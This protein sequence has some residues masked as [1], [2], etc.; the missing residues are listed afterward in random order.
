MACSL[1]KISIE[2]AIADRVSVNLSEELRKIKSKEKDKI[3]LKQVPSLL[4]SVSKKFKSAMMRLIV[5]VINEADDRKFESS[6]VVMRPYKEEAV[7]DIFKI[8]TIQKIVL[9]LG[10]LGTFIGLFIAF[11]NLGDLSKIDDNFSK[12]TNALQYSFSTSIAGLQASVMLAFFLLLLNRRQDSYFKSMEDATQTTIALVRKSLNKDSF[13]ADFEQMRESMDQVRKSVYD[14][15]AE[16]K[17]QTKAIQDGILKLKGAK[18]NFDDFLKGMTQEMKSVYDILSPE[19]ISNELKY[20]LKHSVGGISEAL[21]DNITRHLKQYNVLN[22]SMAK[23]SKNLE[24]IDRQLSGQIELN[25][26][27]IVKAKNEIYKA[28]SNLSDIQKKYI[29]EVAVNHPGKQLEM[30]VKTIERDISGKLGNNANNILDTMKRLERTLKGYSGIIENKVV[31]SRKRVVFWSVLVT[32][33]LFGLLVIA[34]CIFNPN[35]INSLTQGI[36]SFIA[37]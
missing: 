35:L 7:G 12:I 23:I 37:K 27:T 19:K 21:N 20:S 18:T 32:S 6:D 33:L 31:F 30:A 16:T 3:N 34:V 4:P 26:E 24:L 5:Y 28:V 25:N 9:R 13:F 29:K 8:N 17:A 1:I 15:Q 11:A 36:N 2:K 22:E 14:Q 10:I